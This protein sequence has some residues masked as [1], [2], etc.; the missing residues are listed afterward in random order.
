MASKIDTISKRSKLKMKGH[1]HPVWERIS[2]GKAIGYVKLASG[3][4]WRSRLVVD[5]KEIITDKGA[6]E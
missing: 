2:K 4:V 1:G 3:G 5:G 6:P